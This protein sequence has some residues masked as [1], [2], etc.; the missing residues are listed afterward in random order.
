MATQ[1]QFSSPLTGAKI[2]ALLKA[3][4]EMGLDSSATPGRLYI[5]D[6]GSIGLSALDDYRF[7]S[8]SAGLDFNG[9]YSFR[10][11]GWGNY[12][13]SYLL[14]GQS[15][16]AACTYQMLITALVYDKVT[17]TF[18]STG[19]LSNEGFHIYYRFYYGGVWQKWSYFVTSD[20]VNPDSILS[21]IDTETASIVNA[22]D[23]GVTIP[24]VCDSRM[25]AF[26]ADEEPNRVIQE[27]YVS[28]TPQ[29]LYLRYIFRQWVN[30]SNEVCQ[31]ALFNEAGTN[32]LEWY[33]AVYTGDQQPPTLIHLTERN[34]SGLEGWMLVNWAEVTP[35]GQFY[36][37]TPG[38][39]VS[40]KV[41][42]IYMS[43]AL[44]ALRL[45]GVI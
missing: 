26:F 36:V 32:V 21:A 12:M 7:T 4:S 28:G 14:V 30:G 3:L 20:D 41:F 18:A 35:G 38:A 5:R 45:N 15:G 19:R 8:V 23:G 13:T 24:A 29:R 1:Y 16:V 27:A 44:L 39:M 43:P 17:G 10:V 40:S 22:I 33:S 25:N 42:N 6:L 11:S 9:L 2:E 31:V 37:E 34:G